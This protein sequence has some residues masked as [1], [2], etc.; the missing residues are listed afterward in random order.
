MILADEMGLGKTIQS[1]AF[2]YHLYT[3]ENVKGP[4]LVIAP[5]STL[6][7]WKRTIEDWTAL[8]CVLYYD[9]NGQSGRRSIQYYEWY[10]T[11]ITM[12]GNY[13]SSQLN[14]FQIMI[15]SYEVFLLD[16]ASVIVNVP[17]QFIVVD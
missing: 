12:K 9:Q 7:H 8:N 6:E 14:K 10:H 16:F 3:F 4:F 2:L 17:F 11:N 15:T 13:L 5:L 1:I